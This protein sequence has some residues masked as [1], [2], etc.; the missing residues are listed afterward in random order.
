M[1]GA[2]DNEQFLVVPRQLA[3]RGFA[4][5]AGVRLLAMRQQYRR[6]NFAALLQN[7]HIQKR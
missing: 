2:G 4:E 6:A 5:I 3:V 1:A 7:R